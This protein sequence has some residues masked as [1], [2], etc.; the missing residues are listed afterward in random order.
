MLLLSAEDHSTVTSFI[1]Q[2]LSLS[3]SPLLTQAKHVD[4]ITFYSQLLL[5]LT[6]HC[7]IAST[8]KTASSASALN[9]QDSNFTS[10]QLAKGNQE[11]E[12]EKVRRHC[13]RLVQTRELAVYTKVKRICSQEATSLMKV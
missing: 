9:Y 1:V 7:K 3:D 13:E 8:A 12:N 11:K 10:F 2:L 4:L 5:T 6:K